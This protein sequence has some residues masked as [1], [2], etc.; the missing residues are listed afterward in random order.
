MI[1]DTIQCNGDIGMT[2]EWED[3]RIK[4]QVFQNTVLL[5]GRKALVASLANSYG[6]NYDYFISRMAFGEG[7]KSGGVPK[8]VTEER[9]GLFTSVIEKGVIANIDPNDQSQVVFTSVLSRT[10]ANGFSID[11]LGL[12]MNTGLFYSM[13][14]FGGFSKT[15]LMQV[16]FTWRLSFI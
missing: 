11:E 3:G 16:T 2:I 4:R 1:E 5:E 15:S 8:F 7:G 13:S 6:D 10:D 9:T 14:T 12:K